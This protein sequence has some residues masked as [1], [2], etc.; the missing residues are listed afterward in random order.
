MGAARSLAARPLGS[1]T[2]DTAQ[3]AAQTASQPAV[4]RA[5]G[6]IKA[7]NGTSI[8]L[9]PDSGPEISVTVLPTA[10]LLHIA[11]GEKDLSKA[12]AVQMQDLQVGDR[13][14]V[15][16]RAG[17]DA[18]SISALEVLVL[19][20][21]DVESMHT[22]QL[23]DWQKR[24]L[25][26]LVKAVDAT[27]GTVTISVASLGGSK[28]VAIRTS[29]STVFR[30]YSP[31]SVKFDDARPSAL[32]GIQVGDQLRA[33]GDRSSDGA[34]LTAEEIISGSFQNIAGTVISVDASAGTI[35]VQDL[36]G[37]KAMQVKVSSDSQLHTIPAEIAQRIAARLKASIASALPPGAPG[38][39]AASAPGTPKAGVNG[40]NAGAA[41]GDAHAAGG[42]GAGGFGG[43]GMRSGGAPDFQQMLSRMPAVALADLHKG[44]A[45]LIV[46]TQGTATGAGTAIIL[47]SGVE[48][49]LQ[50]A[51][52]GSSAMMLTPWSLGGSPAGAEQ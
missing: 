40:A 6:A 43:G 38:A 27:T 32:Q 14:R 46:S 4:A 21:S 17:D 9:A 10:K 45:V 24:G 51:P 30:R 2:Q 13:V 35:T 37:K 31:D 11:P 52:K 19:S 12:T 5:I 34:E 22:Q 7:V 49:I 18:K 25:G 50:A 42:P 41:V 26:G 3:P 16:G 28:D 8:T 39:S 23:Q 48:P 36:L 20:H 33:R 15:R 1:Q 29:K 44:D 47:L